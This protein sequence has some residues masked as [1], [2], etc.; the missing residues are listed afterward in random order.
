MLSVRKGL[1]L[2]NL[3]LGTGNAVSSERV[4][5]GKFLGLVRV[6]VRVRDPNPIDLDTSAPRISLNHSHEIA[7]CPCCHCTY[8]WVQATTDD[9]MSSGTYFATQVTG[10]YFCSTREI[11][12]IARLLWTDLCSDLYCSMRS[13]TSSLTLSSNANLSL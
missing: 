7:S 1:N 11:L 13:S 4:Q 2:G 6:R 9:N 5:S 12:R 8:V 10:T 3:V